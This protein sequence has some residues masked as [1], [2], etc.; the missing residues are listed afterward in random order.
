[1]LLEH[2]EINQ[3]QWTDADS[4]QLLSKE[5]ADRPGTD[6]EDRAPST[7]MPCIDAVLGELGQSKVC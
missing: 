1:M 3:S 5:A 4:R 6:D 2:I 7:A